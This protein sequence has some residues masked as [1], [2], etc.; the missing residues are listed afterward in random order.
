MVAALRLLHLV[1]HVR[2]EVV[3][4][5]VCE[6]QEHRQHAE[7]GN[8]QGSEDDYNSNIKMASTSVMRETT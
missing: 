5:F 4:Q 6:E 8:C 3:G 1:L 2:R 7:N